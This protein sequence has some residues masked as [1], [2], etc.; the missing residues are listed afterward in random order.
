MQELAYDNSLFS[1]MLADGD[2]VLLDFGVSQYMRHRITGEA[3][4][5]Y[6]IRFPAKTLEGAPFTLLDTDDGYFLRGEGDDEDTYI[7]IYHEL[8]LIN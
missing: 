5:V 2:I 8:K 4:L 7:Y 1:Q 6:D 3:A